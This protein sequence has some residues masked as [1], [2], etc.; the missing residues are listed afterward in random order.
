M[1]YVNLGQTGL[2]VSRICLG[3]MTY[4][5]EEWRPWILEG[6]EARPIVGASKTAHIEEAVAATQLKLS[7]EEMQLLGEVYKPHA[8]LG[9]A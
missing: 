3:M 5:T 9:H 1:D 8:V 2:K 4:G 7:E 6:A